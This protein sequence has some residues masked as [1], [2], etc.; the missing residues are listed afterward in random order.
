MTTDTTESTQ[1]T[2]STGDRTTAE[3]PR[4]QTRYRAEIIPAMQEQFQY[5][6][7]MKVPGL[8]K[9]WS[10]WASARRPGTPS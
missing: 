4:L 8:T 3:R 7:I 10:T 5:S 9:I 6:N 1:S 2:Q